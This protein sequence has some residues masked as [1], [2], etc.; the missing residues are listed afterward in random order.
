MDAT[1]DRRYS[2]YI[3]RNCI[4]DKVYIGQTVQSVN[5]RFCQHKKPSTLKKKGNY[6]IYNAIS[7]YG[8]ENFYIE[9]LEDGLTSA[10]ADE[11][12]VYYIE[13]YDSFDNGYNSTR[14][15]DKKTISRIQDIEKF[16]EMYKEGKGLSFI[17]SF[18]G[19]CDA[20][21]ARTARSLGLSKYNK[22]SREY[23]L[24]NKARKTNIEMAKELGVNEETISRAFAKYGIKR[25]KGC[26][27]KK[28]LQNK[29]KLSIKDKDQFY[30]MWVNRDIPLKNIALRFDVNQTTIIKQAKKFG[31]PQRRSVKKD[32]SIQYNYSIFQYID[33]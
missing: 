10:E 30:E 26:N 6:K 29:P 33:D 14:G 28:S 31:F 7:K 32:Y 20:T 18:F 27:N 9:T 22:V 3:I 15:A 25:G 16:K 8:K 12:E 19:V 23:L 2:I 17:A 4:N 5:D 1:N 24:K 21:V 13:K 11:R